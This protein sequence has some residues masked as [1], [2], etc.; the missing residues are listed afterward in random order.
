[1]K[2]NSY[3]ADSLKSTGQSFTNE[4]TLEIPLKGEGNGWSFNKGSS[5]SQQDM[6]KTSA[7]KQSYELKDVRW[8]GEKFVPK[9]MDLFRIN[10]NELAASSNIASQSVQSREYESVYTVPI[11]L[12]PVNK[13]EDASINSTVD[14]SSHL[15]PIDLAMEKAKAKVGY[16]FKLTRERLSLQMQNF[17]EEMALD[18]NKTNHAANRTLVTFLT[19]H[20]ELLDG[21]LEQTENSAVLMIY[22][23]QRDISLKLRN[24]AW[25]SGKYC[26][27]FTK[28]GFDPF[29]DGH[30]HPA[31]LESFQVHFY[32]FN[33]DMNLDIDQKL[34]SHMSL[35]GPSDRSN[36]NQDIEVWMRICCK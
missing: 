5:G 17:F 1:M 35:E 14:D 6:Q 19:S 30:R 23:N 32:I 11:T 21:K 20:K 4:D 15:V 26:Q 31:T 27:W 29:W 13:T 16:E 34:G 8:E 7:N 36:E 18:V 12:P 10:T 3:L 24:G 25:P 28:G 22:Y 2:N 33:R 9:D